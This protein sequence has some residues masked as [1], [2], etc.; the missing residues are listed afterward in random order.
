M[1]SNTFLRRLILFVVGFCEGYERDM[2]G[3]RGVIELSMD[4]YSIQPCATLLSFSTVQEGKQRTYE[5]GGGLREFYE[6]C[7][8]NSRKPKRASA[9]FA[10]IG[11]EGDLILMMVSL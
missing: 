3:I 6:E 4:A 2:R 1:Q 5:R 9:L 10:R 11:L 7:M 8:C